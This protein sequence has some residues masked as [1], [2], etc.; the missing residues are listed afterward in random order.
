MSGGGLR[1]HIVRHGEAVF[2]VEQKYQG[3][4]D[5]GLTARGHAQARASA[6]ILAALVP[7]PAKV[8]SSDLPRSLDTAAPYAEAVGV[9]IAPDPRWR[10]IDVG[11]WAGRTFTQMRAEEPEVFDALDRGEDVPRGGGETFS[12]ARRRIEQALAQLNADF[13]EPDRDLDVVVFSHGGPIRL[14]AAA[15]LALPAPGHPRLDPPVNCS[16]TTLRLGR[17]NSLRRY[18]HELTAEDAELPI[19]REEVV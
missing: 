8:I 14:A 16:V 9:A 5:S 13:S 18:N 12:Q 7:Q 15:A 10:E 4:A 17:N 11:T 1:V 6:L 2:N 3:Q 19:D